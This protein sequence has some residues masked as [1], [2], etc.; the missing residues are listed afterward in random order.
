MA[1]SLATSRDTDDSGRPTAS[2]RSVTVMGPADAAN[3]APS[4]PTCVSDWKRGTSEGRLT[5]SEVGT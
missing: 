3:S 5:P 1:S 4:T 2:A